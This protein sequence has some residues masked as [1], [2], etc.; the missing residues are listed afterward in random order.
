MPSPA[1]RLT[2]SYGFAHVTISGRKPFVR[3]S[4]YGRL[5][6]I[7]YPRA[8]YGTSMDPRSHPM[9]WRAAALCRTYEVTGPYAPRIVQVAHVWWHDTGH[10]TSEAAAARAAR[11]IS[12]HHLRLLPMH[13]AVLHPR[14]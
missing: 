8:L 12:D 6:R 13:R 1:K 5:V 11:I 7:W 9:T 14:N 4:Y 3:R 2:I 10:R